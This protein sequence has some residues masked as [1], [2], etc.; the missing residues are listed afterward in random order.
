MSDNDLT[1]IRAYCDWYEELGDVLWWRSPVSEAPYVGSPLDLG[2]TWSMDVYNGRGEIISERS[3][4]RF[5]VG[6]W[7]FTDADIPHLWWTPLPDGKL[8]EDQIPL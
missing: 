4:H 3:D 2:A 5:Q 8:I 7:P 1:R 6:A